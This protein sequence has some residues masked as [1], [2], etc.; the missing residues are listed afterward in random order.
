VVTKREL[1]N[2]KQSVF[3]S[4]FHPILSYGLES[5]AM[6]EEVLSQVQAADMGF[7]RRVKPKIV[8]PRMSSH[9]SQ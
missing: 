3:K 1:Y 5:W 7:F 8:I 6:T 2:A 9:F 4:V